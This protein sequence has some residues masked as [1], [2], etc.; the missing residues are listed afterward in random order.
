MTTFSLDFIQENQRRP[1]FLYVAYTI[2]HGRYEVPNAKPYSGRPWPVSVKNYAAMVTRMDIDVGRIMERLKSLDIDRRT[3]VFF[4]S[5]NGA[6][7]HYF[8]RSGEVE[9][10]DEILRSRG[11]FRGFKR[12]L[13]EGGIRVPMIVRWPGRVAAGSENDHVWAFWDFLPTAAEL[14]GVDPPAGV[15]GISVVPTLLGRA[16]KTHEFLYWE[17]FERGFQQA[18][19][20]GDW[21]AIRLKQG[22][23]LVLY[24]VKGDPRNSATLRAS[25]RR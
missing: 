8:R 24:D 4:T 16:Q 18:V 1:F 2:P 14:A 19:R 22:E 21:K 12:D 7:I 10:Y 6:E 25:I 13:T 23:P 20:H 9:Q 15:D 11:P 3:I 17:F 5:D